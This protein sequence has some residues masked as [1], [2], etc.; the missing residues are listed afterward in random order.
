LEIIIMDWDPP[1]LKSSA[2][3]IGDDLSTL[4]VVELGERIDKLKAEIARTEAMMT[5]KRRVNAA[6]DALFGK[7]S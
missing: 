5:E 7:P 4:S 1:K 3:A 6:A 2:V